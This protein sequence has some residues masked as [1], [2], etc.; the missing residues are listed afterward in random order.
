[1][2]YISLNCIYAWVQQTGVAA[3]FVLNPTQI[4]SGV[5]GGNI[6]LAAQK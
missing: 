3:A 4:S 6:P 5:Q 1:M 2:A